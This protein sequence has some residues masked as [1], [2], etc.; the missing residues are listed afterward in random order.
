MVEVPIDRQSSQSPSDPRDIGM[1]HLSLGYLTEEIPTVV[2]EVAGRQV[3]CPWRA[4]VIPAKYV[5]LHKGGRSI[6]ISQNVYDIENSW[7]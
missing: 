6:R 7:N 1:Q 5:Y 3:W 2:V 4:C